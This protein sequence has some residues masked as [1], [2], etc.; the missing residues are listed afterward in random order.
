[1]KKLL[2]AAL[3]CL[4]ILP[5]VSAADN[6][7]ESQL[8]RGI[9]NSAAY[10]YLL[11]EQSR[12]HGARSEEILQKALAYSP[13]LP[14]VYFAL[15]QAS[16]SLSGAGILKSVDY[17]V[18]GVAAYSRNFWWSFTL[19]TSLFFSLVLSFLMSV[20]IVIAMRLFTDIPLLS[21]DFTEGNLHPAILTGFFLISLLGP[22]FLLAG[23]LLLLGLYMKKADKTVV[24]LFLVFLL[25]FPIVVNSGSRFFSA[26]TSGSV[27]SVV[28]V[29]QSQDNK[30]AMTTLKN[31]ADFVPLFS[32]ALA[33]KREGRYE[34][35]IE[36][37]ERL[38]QAGEHPRAYVNLG[39]C[40]VG[41]G[42]NDQQRGREYL[43]QAM[44]NYRTAVHIL[45]LA[46]AYY[47]LSEISREMLDFT[48]GDE[49]FRSAVAID[50]AAVSGYRALYSRN[51]NR[52]V[53]DETLPA[54]RLWEYI[55]HRP[56]KV[57]TF[58]LTRIPSI[59]LPIFSLFLLVF[60]YV[61]DKRL[62]RRAYRCRKCGVILCPKCEK[63]LLWGQMCPQCYGSLIKLD[64]LDA[65]E[66]VSRLLWIYARQRRR[67]TT[68]KVLSYIL[69]G[70][71]QIFAGKIVKGFFLLWSFLFFLT[72]PAM[73]SIF[74]PNNTL[75]SHGFFSCAAIYL[76]VVLF[77]V[78]NYVT[79]KRIS[80]G[81]L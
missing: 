65:R 43:E 19:T 46:S 21:H 31:D 69:P 17:I 76:A 34:E 50:R 10:S 6:F 37:Y 68:I 71:P 73:N 79:R 52:V 59:M 61:S 77:F 60:F 9:T 14:A 40:Y 41:L 27:R 11:I 32:Y 30:Y 55:W 51:P 67:R 44:K 36:S 70:S 75:V 49:Y 39:N 72:V 7:Y 81:W 62:H 56:Y 57:L 47:N 33:L 35:A 24:Y 74:V 3:L 4:F 58:G 25:C 80:R 22:L 54:D 20:V 48:R 13:D 8:N 1:M 18:Q 15:S 78:A 16:F 5:P 28:D 45:P 38:L 66:R 64:E 29:N 12:E 53:A 42:L 2:A 63:G 23:L 26:Y